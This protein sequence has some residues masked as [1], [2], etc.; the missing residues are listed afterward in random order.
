MR[1]FMTC[2]LRRAL[3]C[4]FVMAASAMVLLTACS[5]AHPENKGEPATT[6]DSRSLAPPPQLGTVAPE[7]SASSGKPGGL[8]RPSARD[9]ADRGHITAVIPPK[10]RRDG[11]AGGALSVASF[12]SKPVKSG[13]RVQVTGIC[14][15]QFHV[16]GS[17]GSPPVSRSDWQ[18]ASGVQVVYVVGPMPASCA[19][20][21]TTISATVEIDTAI[22]SGEKQ[23]RRFLAISR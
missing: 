15:D 16:R 14:L 18:L 17:A 3:P 19:K 8:R 5:P 4:T 22:V 10:A 13:Q 12:L 6:P 23:P 7:D 11:T 2:T 1:L 21:S 9:T 20:G